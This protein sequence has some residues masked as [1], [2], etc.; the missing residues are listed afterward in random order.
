[1]ERIIGAPSKMPWGHKCVL[2]NINPSRVLPNA[3][4]LCPEH[5]H[6]MIIRKSKLQEFPAIF[7]LYPDVHTLDVTD[8]NIININSS[9][10]EEAHSLKVLKLS[11]NNM[12][13]LR[14][15]TFSGAS[16]LARLD[17][18]RCNITEINVHTFVGL[19]QLTFLD[20]SENHIHTLPSV[21]FNN[22]IMLKVLNLGSNQIETI[23]F[24]LLIRQGLLRS[25]ILSKN[26]LT[27]ILTKAFITSNLDTLDLDHNPTLKNLKLSE[28]SMKHLETIKVNNCSLETLF[29]P[30]KAI[31]VEAAYNNISHVVPAW[32]LNDQ[33][34]MLRRLNLDHNK[35]TNFGNL[36]KFDKLEMLDLNG[37]L[38]TTLNV[39]QLKFMEKL[40][41][42]QVA[43]N[44]LV[45]A[46]DVSGLA[47]AL[48][49]LQELTISKSKYDDAY[50]SE[51]SRNLTAHKI[52]LIIDE[53]EEFSAASFDPIDKM[54]S[55]REVHIVKMPQTAADLRDMMINMRNNYQIGWLYLME[56]E[57]DNARIINEWT[58]MAMSS[59]RIHKR[60]VTALIWMYALVIFGAIGIV[61]RIFL[62]PNAI[63]QWF[64]GRRAVAVDEQLLRLASPPRIYVR[65]HEQSPLDDEALELESLDRGDCSETL[66]IN[67]EEEETVFRKI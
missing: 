44:P 19:S 55:E 20:L 50:L 62:K 61:C 24:R 37:N 17:L 43:R 63:R 47:K 34:F 42:L 35:L 5:T 27:N 53:E 30:P 40:T 49:D 9:S 6:T 16:F 56:I 52:Q 10:F 11:G 28:L 41:L 39:T 26:R 31:T 64:D 13:S 18:K 23:D 59:E 66:H 14:N 45:D 15:Y 12:T 65:D 8:N 33:D 1:M 48:P 29:V 22:L 32:T 57:S 60:I 2:E 36:T 46:I 54:D 21:V 7:T 4:N 67:D 3:I 38:I 58:S 25:L 51:V